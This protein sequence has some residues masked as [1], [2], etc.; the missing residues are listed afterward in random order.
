MEGLEAQVWQGV[1][2]GATMVRRGR[3]A[4]PAPWTLQEILSF[5]NRLER[6]IY[7]VLLQRHVG[8][9]MEVPA[10]Y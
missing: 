5:S 1:Y 3:G 10:Q 9:E 4:C 2:G 7:L 6:S 8:W